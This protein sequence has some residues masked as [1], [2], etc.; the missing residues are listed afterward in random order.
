L[1]GHRRGRLRGS[2]K[3]RDSRNSLTKILTPQI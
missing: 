2:H 3:R 1:A